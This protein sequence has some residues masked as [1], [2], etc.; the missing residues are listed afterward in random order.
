MCYALCLGRDVE[1][2]MALAVWLTEAACD[3]SRWSGHGQHLPVL[4]AVVETH[5]T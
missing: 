2:G 4:A 1:D 5:R 3:A